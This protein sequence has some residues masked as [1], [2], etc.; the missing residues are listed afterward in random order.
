MLSLLL[1]LFAPGEKVAAGV[2]QFTIGSDG[3]SW[4]WAFFALLLLV[5]LT[6]WSYSRFAPRLSRITRTILVTLRCCLFALLLLLLVR[7]VLYVSLSETTRKSLLVLL[8][9]SESMSLVD[10]RVTADD[11]ARSG[12]ALGVLDP[13]QGLSQTISADK[14]DEIAHISR[15]DLLEAL[16]VNPQINFWPRLWE[17]SDL[18]FY[19]FGRKIHALGELAPPSG[20]VLSLDESGAFFQSLNYTDDSTAIGD[21]LRDLL[22]DQRGQSFSGI[23]LITDGANNAGTSP[24]QAAALARQDGVP[25]FVYGTGITNPQ[26]I[27]VSE[28]TAPATSN[29]KEKLDVIAHIRAKGFAGR[30]T[31]VQLRLAG[32][33]LDEQPLVLSADGEQEIT[34]S[35][36]PDSV[37]PVD[38]EA[39]VPPLAEEAVKDNNSAQASVNIVDDKIKVLLVEGEPRWDFQF[40]LTSLQRDRRIK[41]QAVLLQ[42]DP[43]LSTFPDSPYLDKLPDDKKSLFGYDLIIIGDVDPRDLGDARIKL[44]DEWVSKLGGGL[45]FM[46]G[47]KFDPYA[48]KG[49]PL[50]A[51]LPID[52]KSKPP[53]RLSEEVHL[54][55]TSQGES[56]PFLALSKNGQENLSIWGGFKGV[57]MIT[58]MAKARAAAQ[59][60]LTAPNPQSLTDPIPIIAVQPY[61]LG[62]TLF[63]G[64]PETYVWRSHVGEKYYTQ[65][66]GQMIQGVTAQHSLTG[67]TQLK[68]DKPRYLVGD[69]IKISGHVFKPGFEPMTDPELPGSLTIQ[70]TTVPPSS[71]TASDLVLEAIPGRPGEYQGDTIAQ[72]SGS[73]A[74][75]LARD[76]ETKVKFDVSP[77]RGELSD[78]ALNE[79]LLKAMTAEAGGRF[80]REED[81]NEFP[82]L[83]TCQTTDAVSLKKIPL[84]F[85]PIILITLA[86]L[87]SAEWFIRRRVELK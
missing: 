29:V 55:L 79:K 61:G 9:T 57:H 6:T 75:N 68:T 28:L 17:N 47:P 65:L 30:K 64:T 86:L 27:Y 49:T 80:L 42:G 8:D 7:P 35:Y 15:K 41:V 63:V 52:P 5:A 39:Y 25:L 62:Q 4:G 70:P 22:N 43:D 82:D 60:L 67:L 11:L 18:M 23:L 78:I 69:H 38:L 59:V 50:E 34:L 87:S 76:K 32:K 14:S 73:Y 37:G 44:I 45:I 66:W 58:G 46:G 74:Y 72:V 12:I 71:A 33:V 54:K 26:D 84:S 81:L 1:Y 36:T 3:L 2:T 24:L 19:G 56:S 77:P 16:A 10:R 20:S 13:K 83:V 21:G 51:L 48:Y 31:K 85:A 53:E 40:L